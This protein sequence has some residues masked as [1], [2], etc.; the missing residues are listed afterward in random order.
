VTEGDSLLLVDI[1]KLDGAVPDMPID[2]VLQE[3]PAKGR[4]FFVKGGTYYFRVVGTG[5]WKL[6]VVQLP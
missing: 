5:D 4:R 6:T 3:G 2:T 1:N